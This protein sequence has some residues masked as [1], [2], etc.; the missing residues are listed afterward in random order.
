MSIVDE[1]K[2]NVDDGC[3]G[4]SVVGRVQ[5]WKWDM[6][7]EEGEWIAGEDKYEEEDET[8]VR[9][10]MQ[11]CSKKRESSSRSIMCCL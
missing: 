3:G 6:E 1:E 11:C 9:A 2:K 7:G 10:G 5:E 4:A 8:G